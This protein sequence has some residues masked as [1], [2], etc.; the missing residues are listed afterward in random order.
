MLKLIT[1]FIKYGTLDIE[2]SISS[3]L[4]IFVNKLVYTSLSKK[5]WYKRNE[6][7]M[8]LIYSYTL[9]NMFWHKNCN[10]SRILLYCGDISYIS[11]ICCVISFVFHEIS[12]LLH[13]HLY[14]LILFASNGIIHM[15]KCRKL[16]FM[17]L[18]KTNK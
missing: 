16:L 10:I 4:E 9:F 7:P 18:I 15:R 2:A 3:N 17:H 14:F 11:V 5:D 13:F 6:K 8:S 1:T 12:I